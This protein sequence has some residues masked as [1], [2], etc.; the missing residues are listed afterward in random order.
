[1]ENFENELFSFLKLVTFW[2]EEIGNAEIGVNH[3]SGKRDET[4]K[5]EN[6]VAFSANLHQQKVPTT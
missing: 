3:G 5:Y 2:G 1:M 6:Y 4:Q